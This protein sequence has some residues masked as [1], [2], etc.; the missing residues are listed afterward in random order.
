VCAAAAAKD[1]AAASSGRFHA[2]I[3]GDNVEDWREAFASFERPSISAP[4]IDVDTSDGFVTRGWRDRQF[5]QP[6]VRPRS[7]P[8]GRRAE[9]GFARL[10]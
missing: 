4:S 1:A 7:S 6:V 2:R 9:A 10:R 8:Y 5:R 3:I